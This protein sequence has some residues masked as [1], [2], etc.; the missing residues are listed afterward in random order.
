MAELP[1][2]ANNVAQV[3][4]PRP[5]VSPGQIAAPFQEL[6]A[7][8]DKAGDVL[9]KDVAVP[10]ATKAGTASVRA[11]PDGMPIVDNG[12]LPILGDAGVSYGRAQRMAELAHLQPQIENKL[13]EMRLQFNNNPAGYK[14]AV[15]AYTQQLVENT[16][17]STLHGPIQKI[18]SDFGGQQYRSELVQTDNTAKQNALLG[19]Q[20]RLTDINERGTSL[21][22][23]GG[24][25]TPEYQQLHS[26]RAAILKELTTNPDYHFPP[27]RADQILRE[28][29]DQDVEQAVIG[30]VLRTYKTKQN[31]GEARQALQDAFWG[32]G[33][34][35]L[36]LSAQKRDKGITEG[37]AA[38]QRMTSEE[39]ADTAAFRQTVTKYSND[40]LKAPG[41]FDEVAHSAL[42][43]RSV[44]VGDFRTQAELDAVRTMVPLWQAIRGLTPGQANEVTTQMARGIVPALPARLPTAQLDSLIENEARRQGI[45]P[46]LAKR[47]AMI[48]SG[49]NP[50][51]QDKGSSYKGLFQLSTSELSKYGGGDIFDPVANSRAG[52]ASLAEKAQNFRAKFGRDPS[53]TELYLAHQQGE[54]GLAAHLANPN[55]PAWQNMASTGEGQQKG[56]TWAKKAVWGNVPDTMKSLFPGGVDTVTSQQFMDV[57]SQKVQGIP[58]GGNGL[59]SGQSIMTARNPYVPKLFESTVS[60]MRETQGKNAEQL[61]DHII[62]SATDRNAITADTMQTFV[63]ASIASGKE[64]LLRKVQ[65]ALQAFDA[66]QQAQGG[67][68]SVAAALDSQIKAAKA[69]GTDPVRSTMLSNLDKMVKDSTEEMQ[70]DPLGEGARRGWVSPINP[71]DTS[72]GQSFSAGLG[73]RQAKIAVMRQ[74]D[75]TMGPTKAFSDG[76]GLAV[77]TA[78]TQG[79]PAVAK[80]LLDGMAGSLSPDNYRATMASKPIR[81]AL[82]GMVRSYDPARLNAGMSTLDSLW[83]ADP[84]GFKSTWGQGGTM[85]RLQTWQSWRDSH[86]PAEIAD[87]F[88]Q[89]DDPAFEKARDTLRDT[90]KTENKKI[91]PD[92]IAYQMG[93]SLGIPVVSRLA[94]YVTGATPS[95]P[96]DALQAGALKAEFDETRTQLRSM[97]INPDDATKQATERL[98]AVWGAS[99]LTGQLMRHPPERYYPAVSGSHAWMSAQLH[100]TVQA[101]RGPQLTNESE[102]AGGGTAWSVMGIV[103]DSNT[104]AEISSGRP[105][106]YQIIVKDGITGQLQK[107]SDPA[108]GRT[109]FSFDPNEPIGPNREQFQQARK[110]SLALAGEQD[111]QGEFLKNVRA[112]AGQ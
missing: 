22:R 19:L 58:F 94:N 72:S 51:A 14:Q 93:T 7:T 100:D 18:A 105:P 84:V 67:G 3:T 85:D 4:T 70:K 110:G 81:E 53:A 17:D 82:D 33:S 50:A 59:V 43:A 48:E 16:P 54:A 75:P 104:E 77:K 74:T 12:P 46:Q 88:K 41:M 62:K 112:S 49:G 1:S 13:S 91:T 101:I 96:S 35:K 6:A 39:R 29:R 76:E 26:D 57:W 40:V 28:G 38:L 24:V 65:P 10:L 66:Y 15:G 60:Q 30:D 45:D 56:D 8:M 63:A 108:T 52:I 109:R 107:L 5:S 9:S 36:A 2:I 42:V 86:S 111:K 71:I 37:V 61:A 55:A 73:E 34:E 64:D 31:A 47:V 106:A 23:Q 80:Q 21:A 68:P 79:D 44:Q 89:A 83:R 11:G 92:D 99:E 97:G 27:E 102:K 95:V 90:A 69:A 103:P 20:A 98:K 32:P 25:N 78:L 87:R